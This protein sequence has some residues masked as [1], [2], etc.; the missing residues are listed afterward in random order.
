MLALLMLAALAGPEGTYVLEMPETASA[1]RLQADGRYQW[2]FSQGALDVS[3]DG[4]WVREGGSILLT[5]DPIVSPRFLFKEA[6]S[7]SEAGVIIEVLTDKGQPLQGIDVLVQY[8]DGEGDL[9]Y[10]D[11]EGRHSFTIRAAG[12]IE[13]IAL[14]EP[15]FGVRSENFVLPVKSG[16]VLSFRLET[17]DWGKEAFEGLPVRIT[18][19][20]AELK[21]RDQPLRYRKAD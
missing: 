10:T 6:K 5:S 14:A 3:S 4:K 11:A 16:Q 7:G 12:K 21:W 9:G 17:N 1:L 15:I 20:G 13:H 2:Y 19:E 18:S 8:D